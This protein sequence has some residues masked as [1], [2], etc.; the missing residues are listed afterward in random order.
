MTRRPKRR[1]PRLQNLRRWDG[2]ARTSYAWDPEVK[3]K[4]LWVPT[5]NCRVYLYGYGQSRRE[6]SFK[7]PFSELQ[8]QRCSPLIKRYLVVSE[9]EACAPST[10]GTKRRSRNFS[11][12]PAWGDE[13][14]DLYIPAPGRVHE[15][16]FYLAVRNF[17]AFILRKSLAAMHLGNSMVQLLH[18]MNEYR[19]PGVDN[20]GDLTSFLEEEGYLFLAGQ[21][22]HAMAML[23]FGESL[24]IRHFYNDAFAHCVGM[25]DYLHTSSEY[26]QL[27]PTAR[28]S[29]RKARSAME[30]RLSNSSKMLRN[31]LENDLSE[32]R[33]GLTP[34]VRAHLDRFRG[35]IISYYATKFG[36]WPPRGATT[37]G[38][39]FSSKV[40]SNMAKDFGRL[41][42][43]LVD[44][45]FTFSDSSPALAQG[46][47]CVLQSVQSFDLEHGFESLR[48][49]LPL[50]PEVGSGSPSGGAAAAASGASQSPTTFNRSPS[51][52]STRRKSWFSVSRS[53]KSRVDTRL[54][55]EA[56]LMEASNP[57][58]E[59]LSNDFVVA[60]QR[61]EEELFMS[62][63][64]NSS[65]EKVSLVDARKVRWILI[66]CTYQALLDCTRLPAGVKPVETSYNMCI[67]NANLPT[68]NE[69][70]ARPQASLSDE[71]GRPPLSWNGRCHGPVEQ[72]PKSSHARFGASTMTLEPDVNYYALTHPDE[73][74]SR[75]RQPTI[76][77]PTRGSS[78]TRGL[79]N[80][81][82]SL[83]RASSKSGSIRQSIVGAFSSPAQEPT[84][85]SSGRR[86]SSMNGYQA[87]VVPGYGNGI[88]DFQLRSASHG[89]SRSDIDMQG[90]EG[91]SIPPVPPLPID[92]GYQDNNKDLPRNL[93]RPRA[94]H[95]QTTAAKRGS[96]YI[97][98]GTLP[99]RL[100]TQ[101][102]AFQTSSPQQTAQRTSSTSSQSSAA[103]SRSQ[104]NFSTAPTTPLFDGKAD[105]ESR[106]RNFSCDSQV[107]LPH[108]TVTD[109]ML[110]RNN[111]VT[112]PLPDRNPARRLTIAG[113]LGPIS[114]LMA[115][116]ILGVEREFSAAPPSP[117]SRAPSPLR[118][119]K[120]HN[121]V[122]AA[123][124]SNNRH[125]GGLRCTHL[126]PLG[127][128]PTQLRSS[129][130]PIV[131]GEC[132]GD[133]ASDYETGSE[134]LDTHSQC[135]GLGILNVALPDSDYSEAW[136]QFG[137]LG[138][139]R[140]LSTVVNGG[141]GG[142][143]AR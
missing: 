103:T 136:D 82:R 15:N 138:G 41:Y 16:D 140:P 67:D 111:P 81:P 47:I 18:S 92:M 2:A 113:V 95:F 133:S 124:S 142:F 137:G 128:H 97:A 70:I 52:N 125:D 79:G 71:R 83:S 31:F 72:R 141:K 26:L 24:R 76:Q 33:I 19:E 114:G 102:L 39:I 11:N 23:H 49:P 61:F 60:Y 1:S 6:P 21:P 50:L 30:A 105:Y 90:F 44:E 32:Q 123:S 143:G 88:N 80:L 115:Q 45:R 28:R 139:L 116:E 27:S 12:R 46:G 129:S 118:I 122:A 22:S 130:P 77:V 68:W 73:C 54:A 112:P 69:E 55:E 74:E 10:T 134:Y 89:R 59:I 104:G 53:E 87:I 4:A 91:I 135:D 117:N 37:A 40:Y 13:M 101:D 3:D 109:A 7:L 99:S 84:N 96:I 66:Y 42:E 108:I 36:H 63:T 86:K 121:T 35:F 14:F 93:S 29:V 131:C 8:D 25:A 56:A 20:V 58:P 127:S 9:P 34:G 106:D 110:H 107:T 75:G 57:K 132:Y 65:K 38:G 100:M 5:G 126:K 98:P 48:N 85:K 51:T 94:S 120:M 43:Y 17:F 64:K 78:L 62:T 119:N